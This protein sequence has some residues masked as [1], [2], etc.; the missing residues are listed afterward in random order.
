MLLYKKWMQSIFIALVVL[1]AYYFASIIVSSYFVL[2]IQPF[3]GTRNV[4]TRTI[5]TSENNEINFDSQFT[6]GKKNGEDTTIS[7]HENITR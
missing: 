1:I 3:F 2:R 5:R 6:C 4:I 7:E